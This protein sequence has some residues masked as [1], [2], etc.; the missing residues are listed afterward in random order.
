MKTL[1]FPNVLYTVKE[2]NIN[3]YKTPFVHPKR[4]MA[5]YDFIYMLDGKWKIGQGDTE[6]ALSKDT[7]LI[8]EGGVLHFGISPCD[9][10]TKTMYFH[11]AIPEQLPPDGEDGFSLC[12]FY[13]EVP[14]KVKKSFSNVV[15]SYLEGNTRRANLYFSLLLCD[16]VESENFTEDSKIATKIK[17]KIHEHPECFFSNLELAEM[18]NVSVKTA[19]TK[20]KAMYAMSI[21]QYILQ[22]KIREAISY[23]DLFPDITVKEVSHNLG[24]FDEYHFSKTFKKITGKS[25]RQW[26]S[27]GA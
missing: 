11:I 26:K 1:F 20:F 7:L 22:F 18:V 3:C 8:L 25:P 5:E 10:G 9:A 23:F 15:R 13:R 12:N 24:F 16:L 14:E 21:H 27:D 17:T 6:Y 2:A 4:T 19:E